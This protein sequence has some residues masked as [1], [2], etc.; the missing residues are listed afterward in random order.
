[1][2]RRF[3]RNM[4]RNA[5]CS[6][7]DDA[8]RCFEKVMTLLRE[9]LSQGHIL[10]LKAVWTYFSHQLAEKYQLSPGDYRSNRFKERIQAFLGEDIA[11]VLPL[12]P[13]EP[14]LI[15]YANL[16]EVALRSLLTIPINESDDDDLNGD[17]TED[18]DLDAE[19]LSWLYRVAVKVHHDIKISPNHDCIGKISKASAEEIVPESL[20][21]LISL[22]CSGYQEGFQESH[23]DVKT[24]ILSICQDIIFLS[25]RGYTFTP[26]HVGIGLTVHQ[27]TR[28]KQLVQ[29]LHAAGHSA[30][31]ETVLRM[32]NTIANDVL[33]RYSESGNVFVPRNFTG[34][35]DPAGYTRFA[36]DNI[37]IN[38]ETLNGMGTFQ[39]TQVAAFRRKEE[40]E[41]AMDIE[42]SPKSERHLDVQVPSELH[43]LADLLLDNKKPEPELQ[44][45]VV[46]EWY[47]PDSS[48]INEYYKKDQA[49]ILGRLHEQ[50]PELQ[51][52]PGWTGFNQLL[53]TVN[54]Q[55][56][57]VG[58]LPI[59]NAPAHEFETLWKVILRCK[60]MTHLRNGKFTVITMDEGLY[61]KAKMLQWGKTQVLKDVIIVLGGFHT[62]MTF[63]KVIG[64][65]L[66]S[67]GM[68]E[69]WA[70]S[71]VFGE[72]TA[73]NILKGK[74]WNRV[75]RA[76][77]LSY[78]ALWRVLWPILTKRA[79]DKDDNECNTLVNLSETLATKFTTA[80]NN[81]A[82]VDALTS[83]ELVNEVGQVA[84]I[85]KAFDA[86]HYDNPSFC[87]WRQY[88]KLVSILLRFT[89]VI[90]EGKWDL[91]LSSFFE[92]LP[93]TAP[94]VQQAF[95][96]GDFVTKETASTFNQISDHQ[97]LEHVNKS[98][99]VAG[100]VVGITRTDSARD[101]WCLTYNERAKLSE[102]TKEMFNVLEREC[103]S[104]KDLG[105][106][107]M[108]QDAEDVAK[109]EAQFTKYE[110]FRCTSDLVVVTTGDVVSNAIKQDLLGIEEI[111]KKVIKE[112]VE[113]RL[114]K[115][116]I[117][118]H[119][120]LKQQK[121]K[122]FETLYTVPVSVDKSKTS[123]M[124]ADKDLLRRVIVALESGRDVDVN[125][126]LQ[127]E[128]A[129]V[130]KSL[131]TLD[132]SLR[133]AGKSDLGT[134][135]QGNV[136][137]SQMPIS[138]SQTCTI[139]DGMAAVQS[140]ANSSGA[141]TFVNGVTDFYVMSL[142][143]FRT[144]VQE[145]TCYLTDMS[146]TR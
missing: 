54:P 139:I 124:K 6:E 104:A 40:G 42:L 48:L 25:S 3:L 133:E 43:E 140:F 134:I 142:T 86:A 51:S 37:D 26:K 89:R 29:L 13:S 23:D 57:V 36:V 90:R 95:E 52:I 109:L 130:P 16:G 92:M 72:T 106:A 68:A 137:K 55:V 17:A 96:S 119:D 102:D 94:E 115:K 79:K 123:A 19:L 88:M 14:H 4:E 126:L 71:E 117:K 34:T 78:E 105:K 77:K 138:R 101:C 8:N 97:A 67:S 113:T 116:E 7:T 46:S 20:F 22:L 58:P 49:C 2:L 136:C 12:N 145:L 32:D 28:S 33:Q 103:T 9:R 50:K 35:T 65:Y 30:N 41:P 76:H 87:Y 131:A 62:L 31:Y 111:G 27:A 75:I 112:F 69:M 73:G 61:N 91:Y 129:P 15:V 18:V 70:E 108:R 1:M 114:I 144:V 39:A 44:K 122:T 21:M 99:K 74:L 38:E 64:K 125:T 118:F 93:Q 47:T 24:C 132:G 84:R 98:G 11:F 56:T 100:G 83:N 110:V 59:V 127:S 146:R 143:I 82:L 45:T 5:Q 53:A 120:T 10:S 80:N 60:A 141:K 85:I 121:V 128:L 135:L 63:S 66:Q 107:R 81:D